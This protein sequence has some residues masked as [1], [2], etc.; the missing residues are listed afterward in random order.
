MAAPPAYLLIGHI[1][2]DVTPDGGRRLGGTVSYAA[3]T[4]HAFGLPV[5][6]LTSAAH[7]EPLLDELAPYVTEQCIIPAKA[8][9]TFE[10]VY[11][12]RGQRTQYIRAVASALHAQDMPPGWLSTPL[13]HLAPL[14]GEVD[15]QLA[16]VFRDSTV[17]VTLQ[18]W[19]REWGADGWVHF[20]RW[21]DPAVLSDIDIVVFS[22]ED[23]R[24]APE[25]EA[26]Y[27]AA[28]PHLFV[29]RAENGGTYY[30]DGRPYSYDTP[31]FRE[32][33]PTGAGD[34]FAASVLASLSI[35][36]GNMHAAAE[37][38]AYLG[39]TAI[40]RPWL[41]GAPTAAEVRTALAEVQNL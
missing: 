33:N 29:T 25:L 31:H 22:E 30:H 24:D 20:R 36:N 35:V 2:A 4:V 16:H 17:M 18:G 10:N 11:D 23:I 32:V 28:V 40:T 38:A 15:P 37:V 5:R 27:A 21:F 14:T 26:L 8:T 3:R 9:S 12:S 1:T 34:V 39:A 19:L 41:E 7:G 6:L 13:V